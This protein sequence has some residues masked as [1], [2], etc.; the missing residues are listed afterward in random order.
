MQFFYLFS[1]VVVASYAAAL[2]QPAELSKQYSNSVDTTLASG[3]EAR[4]YQPGLNSYK[5]SPTL[6]S[7]ER[8][9]DSEGSSGEDSESDPSFPST[10]GPNKTF[11]SYFSDSDVSSVN[12]AS[13]INRV[14]DDAYI[15]FKDG[16]LAA[17]KIGDPVRDMVA[18]Y[19]RRY[20]YV[21]AA[22]SQWVHISVDGIVD[23]IKS[24]LGEDEHSKEEPDLTEKIK[25]L[26]VK[27][28]ADLNAIGDA[29]SNILKDVGFFTENFQNINKLFGR[30]FN[31][32]WTLLWELFPLLKKFEAGRAIEWDLTSVVHNVSD[33]LKEQ[34][35]LFG[36]IMEKL[37]AAS[38]Q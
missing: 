26:E 34:K 12:L 5:D 23:L 10:S 2:P 25:K 9:D 24:S 7:L 13:T 28:N 6:I 30:T 38:S 29:T 14:K 15:F 21:T 16:E 22:L 8:R 31:S 18:S 37:E 33:F 19:F 17:D 32:R 35:K 20:A 36:K 4:S 3:L 1:F 27:F 11:G